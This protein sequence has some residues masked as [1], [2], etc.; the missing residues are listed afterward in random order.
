MTPRILL[1]TILLLAGL[2]AAA[3]G[4][5]LPDSMTFPHAAPIGSSVS[6][7]LRTERFR[8][9]E[10]RPL[11]P[12]W[13][14]SRSWQPGD[15]NWW[16][17]FELPVANG[18][19]LCAIEYG[20]KLI[21][22]G[23]FSR[24]G[25]VDA[26]NLAAW[27][28]AVWTEVGGGTDSRVEALH[29]FEGD[30]VIGGYF[31]R[32]GDVSARG[33]ARWDGT[34]WHAF[35]P[36]LGDPPYDPVYGAAGASSFETYQGAL[37][38]CGEFRVTGQ[39][40]LDYLARWSGS[41]WIPV[42]DD[43]DGP[44]YDLATVADT[45][46]IGGFF[47]TV[48]SMA[49]AG[50]ARWNGSAWS[51]VGAGLHTSYGRPAVRFLQ[52]WRERIV[53]SGYFETAD[54][55]QVEGMAV[56]NGTAWESLGAPPYGYGRAMTVEGNDLIALMGG[57]VWRWDGTTWVEFPPGLSGYTGCL[58]HYQ[59]HLFVGGEVWVR[60]DG[61]R[62]VAFGMALFRGGRWNG[63]V[64]WTAK[65]HG[66]GHG[67]WAEVR[68]LETYRGEILALGSFSHAGNPPTWT[69]TPGI[70]SWNGTSWSA[71]PEMTPYSGWTNSATVDRDTL[72]VCGAYFQNDTY[73]P[74]LRFDGTTW[75]ALDTLRL[76]A[77]V[78][79]VYEGELY[80]AGEEIFA[81]EPRSEVIRWRSG[82]WERVG[83]PEASNGWNRRIW[84]MQVYDGKLYV[85]GIFDG[86]SGVS[87]RNVAAWNG[88]QWEHAGFSRLPVNMEVRSFA[89]YQ[90]A[91][92]AT[93]PMPYG[94]AVMRRQDDG[95]WTSI[96]PVYA[97]GQSLA[98]VGDELYLSGT[99]WQ[100]EHGAFSEGVMRW[101][102]REWTPLGSGVN[103]NVND[104][105][106]WGGSLYVGGRFTRAGAHGSFAIARWDGLSAVPGAPRL[107]LAPGAPNPFRGS[108]A[109]RFTLSRS[110]RVRISVHDIR[111]REIR[112]IEDGDRF[113]GPNTVVWDGR[114]RQG[115]AA[116]SGIYYL[117]VQLPDGTERSRRA[118][119]I[120]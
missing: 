98:S 112:V 63:I 67:Y 64:P 70:A 99:I 73:R 118:V 27:D 109:F 77:V 22:G 62:A 101:N 96:G 56:W 59:S 115:S 13:R 20:G 11:A 5:P 88:S 61:G 55:I 86:I 72:Y 119:L 26:D 93:G 18:P 87:S 102:G 95:T 31:S 34:Q 48:D 106:V 21:V 58:T 66:L 53:A 29:L 79:A 10:Q 28:G 12:P 49:A 43:L 90:N 92:H 46:Y 71:L 65:M 114:T 47:E 74:V 16:D 3:A 76:Q 81:F 84:A 33:V 111:G 37:L 91:L 38:A 24:I 80:L 2:P 116:P 14:T 117:R 100:A 32:A 94:S 45:L 42:V 19:V 40:P 68:E 108:S 82:R 105:E 103:G 85:G 89:V 75:S 110:G 23:S 120:R 30:L 107:T 1:V 15:E 25:L 104:L 39:T 4:A 41:A 57:G 54:S 51:P 9:T 113:V 52:N 8:S 50:I 44:V 97:Y 7:P 69:E 6:H 60:D 17:G 36:G 78:A 35:G 83:V